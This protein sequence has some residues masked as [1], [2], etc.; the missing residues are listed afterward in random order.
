MVFLPLAL[1]TASRIDTTVVEV[2][3]KHRA[4]DLAPTVS[5]LMAVLLP[6]N[7]SVLL[8]TLP[9]AVSRIPRS[10]LPESVSGTCCSLRIR[11]ASNVLPKGKSTSASEH[12]KIRL[13]VSVKT[14]LTIRSL[15]SLPRYQ[16]L[17]FTI[18][19]RHHFLPLHYL[20]ARRQ[21]TQA[22]H[23]CSRRQAHPRQQARS[24]Q[25]VRSL[26]HLV[27]QSLAMIQIPCQV[28]RLLES[29][30]VV[31]QE[32]PRPSLLV[33]S[34]SGGVLAARDQRG[35]VMIPRNYWKRK[36]QATGCATFRNYQ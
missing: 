30:W 2:P 29:S 9:G 31:L 6:R 32:L 23:L 27:P 36:R 25:Q 22:V 1:M 12:S 8:E 10:A 35:L 13:A 18:S 17:Q 33:T 5:V 26:I 21:Y 16:R 14:C 7:S 34:S 24:D 15:R 3:F 11:Y 4:A 19:M 20:L 28:E